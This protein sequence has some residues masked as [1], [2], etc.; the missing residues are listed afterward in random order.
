MPSATRLDQSDMLRLIDSPS[1]SNRPTSRVTEN[2][3]NSLICVLLPI[4][5]CCPSACAISMSAIASSAVLTPNKPDLA[6]ASAM[7][8]MSATGTKLLISHPLI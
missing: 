2:T 6:T 1:N 7:R 3:A 8:S 4:A 5:G